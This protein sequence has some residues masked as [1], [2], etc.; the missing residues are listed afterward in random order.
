MVLDPQEEGVARDLHGFD[1]QVVRGAAA[2]GHTGG[3]Q[4]FPVVVVE[5]VAV[6][7]PLEN[8]VSAVAFRHF[9]A[10]GDDA[11]AGA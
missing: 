3:L 10:R 6:T 5:L 4:G 11:G 9:G 7:V 2:K 1:Q 8:P